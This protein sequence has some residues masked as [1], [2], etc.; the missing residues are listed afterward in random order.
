MKPLL[1]LTIGLSLASLGACGS[2]STTT[3]PNQLK[4]AHNMWVAEELRT[5]SIENGVTAERSVYEHHFVPGTSEL[6]PLGLRD[7]EL[8]A[9]HF[10]SH[11]GSLEVRRGEASEDLYLARRVAVADELATAGIDPERIAHAADLRAAFEIESVQA[12]EGR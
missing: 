10:R 5:R 6:N 8:L 12:E 9:R 7:L 1:I 2:P 11:G 3:R 4:G